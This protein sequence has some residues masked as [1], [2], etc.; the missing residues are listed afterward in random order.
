MCEEFAPWNG[1]ARVSGERGANRALKHP[2][3]G[4]RIPKLPARGS[5]PETENKGFAGSRARTMPAG[6]PPN[7]K[8]PARGSRPE[9]EIKGFAR[10]R[11]RTMPA[12]G[13]LISKF[14]ARGL[15]PKTENKGL[16]GE[17][18]ANHAGRRTRPGRPP[19]P[20][21]FPAGRAPTKKHRAAARRFL[22]FY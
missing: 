5:R 13:P 17:S 16:A 14:P 7:P 6:G 10:S 3:A 22:L 12:A 4:P 9:T 19:G 21:C 11:A 1:A 15:R 8:F 20:L 2:A 18:S